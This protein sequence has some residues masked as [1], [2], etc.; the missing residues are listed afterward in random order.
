MNFDKESKSLIFFLKW[1][2]G[3][4]GGGVGE[5]LESEGWGSGGGRSK[6]V[7]LQTYEPSKNSCTQHTVFVTIYISKEKKQ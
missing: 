5:R 6:N 4:G 7:K 2:G 1:G 3:G